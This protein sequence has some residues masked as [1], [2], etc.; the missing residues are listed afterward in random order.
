MKRFVQV[1]QRPNLGVEV[2]TGRAW[3]GIDRQVGHGSADALFALTDEQYVT[4]LTDEMLVQPFAM[5]SWRG[6]HEDLLLFHPRSS[7]ACPEQ[8]FPCRT[9]A[10][11]PRFP[12]EIWRHVDALGDVDGEISRALAAGTATAGV[13]SLTFRLVGDNAY[14]R[15]GAL[16]AGLTAGSDRE[17]ARKILGDPVAPDVHTI[18]GDRLRLGYV[19]GGLAE[20][21][22]ERPVPAPPPEGPV[23]VYLDVL[24]EPEGGTAF[25][26][27]ARLGGTSRRWAASAWL[28]RR[29]IA[30][31]DGV[32]V[33][34]EHGR[35]LSARVDVRLLPGWTS[36]DDVHRD[37][38][39]PVATSK[40]IDLHRYT[41]GDLVVEY[42]HETP[43]AVT[44]VP[45]GISVSH[46][47][48]RWRSGE[49]TLFLDILGRGES[50]PLVEQVRGLA[51]VR[52][53][54]RGD[55]VTEVEIGTRGYQTERFAAFIDGLPAQPT[56]KD[57]GLSAP[58][59]AGERD[60]LRHFGEEAWIHVHA[61]DSNLVTSI[62]I[63]QE[64]PRDVEEWS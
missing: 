34:V 41:T 1:T 11:P 53:G 49:F 61:S 52:L 47:F 12:G 25:Q 24:G 5:E 63:S 23:R 56:R 8:W 7:A 57:I 45:C 18:E 60:D 3:M 29:L 37:L 50:D 44:A 14:P 27:V 32:D 15:P 28:P 39:A 62:T 19:D 9:R 48:Y 33:Q 30:F 2:S 22:L 36:R 58:D 42:D 4:S 54:M 21:V 64:P 59:H 43:R 16:I 55:V 26:A 46:K 40:G 38:G 6:E 20:I 31:D 17:R 35:V 13:R 51:G 10:L